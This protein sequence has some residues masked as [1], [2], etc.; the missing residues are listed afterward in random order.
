MPSSEIDALLPAL[1]DQGVSVVAATAMTGDVSQRRYL[2]LTLESDPGSAVLALYPPALLT[3]ARR[4]HLA[5][6]LFAGAGLRVPA[7][8]ATDPLGRWIV[9]EDLGLANVFDLRNEPCDALEPFFFAAVGALPRIAGIDR[10]LVAGLNPP[11]DAALL[12]RELALTRRAFFEP[13]GLALGAEVEAALARLC[14]RLGDE[15]RVPCHRDFGVRNLLPLGGG[16]GIVDHQDL[17]LGPPAYDLASLLNDSLFPSAELEERLLQAAE[18][19][20]REAYHRT[21]AQRTLKAVGTYAMF[22]DRSPRYLPLI[23]PTL[24]RALVHL[25]RTPE[26]AALAPEL[27]ER[28]SGLLN[29]VC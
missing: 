13:R 14:A 20:N 9:T 7:I 2:R 15:P 8:L 3:A 27:A 11:L 5:T 4:Y 18:I 26:T 21:A 23:A 10:G 22:S 12:G 25:A 1:R 28:W 29:P 17:R 24:Q 6:A 19:V 16:V